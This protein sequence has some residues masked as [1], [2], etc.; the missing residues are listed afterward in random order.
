MTILT[1]IYDPV[2]KKYNTDTIS[3]K[4]RLNLSSMNDS[5]RGYKF[6]L[7][8]FYGEYSKELQ[9]YKNLFNC[10][11]GPIILYDRLT[12]DVVSTANFETQWLVIK[13]D[14]LTVGE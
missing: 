7:T 13:N 1:K 9:S 4:D 2:N 8:S 11:S 6:T 3:I 10:V 5:L 12:A 14:Y